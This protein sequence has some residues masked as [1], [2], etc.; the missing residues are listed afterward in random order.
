MIYVTHRK[1]HNN[2]ILYMFVY[3]HV[4][5]FLS[6]L[7]L[8]NADVPLT[9]LVQT[10]GCNTHVSHI[11]SRSSSH[12]FPFKSHPFSAATWQDYMAALPQRMT[13][14]FS[15]TKIWLHKTPA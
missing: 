14:S 10:L 12:V 13:Q 9:W 3:K 4:A 11:V 8:V 6:L 7:F 5:P 15:L 2:H 1:N